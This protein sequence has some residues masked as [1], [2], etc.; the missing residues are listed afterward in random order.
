M[1]VTMTNRIDQTFQFQQ[2]ALRL[3][4]AREELLSSNIANADTPHYLARDFDF[5]NALQTALGNQAV[6][7]VQMAASQPGHITP[8]AVGGVAGVQVQYRSV[9]QPSADGN[10]VDMNQEQAQFQ[11]NTVRYESSLQF[12]SQQIKDVITALTG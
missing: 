3:R 8:Q 9:V 12:V 5:A 4:D 10:T 11:E 6:P 2:T 1:G 7:P